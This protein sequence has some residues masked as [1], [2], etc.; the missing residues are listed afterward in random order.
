LTDIKS[1]LKEF[2][3]FE[4]EEER[5][6]ICLTE[7]LRI[8]IKQK[9]IYQSCRE[10]I[11]NRDLAKKWYDV[12]KNIESTAHIHM[13]PGAETEYGDEPDLWFTFD[14]NEDGQYDYH[15]ECKILRPKSCSGTDYCSN[16][17]GKGIKRYCDKNYYAL[18]K[19]PGGTMIGYVLDGD[20]KTLLITVNQKISNKNLNAICLLGNFNQKDVTHLTQSIQRSSVPFTLN[21]LWADFRQ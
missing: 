1:Q 7:M 2:K 4:Y 5:I 20:L 11:I 14:D 12:K 6:L 9:I 3:L 19:P 13:L 17:V 15:V 18:S 16:Y 21:H 10:P 8:L